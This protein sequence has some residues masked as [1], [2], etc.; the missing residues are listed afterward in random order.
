[1]LIGK[2]PFFLSLYLC[3]VIGLTLFVFFLILPFVLSNGS[4]FHILYLRDDNWHFPSAKIHRVNILHPITVIFWD[5]CLKI[6]G[7]EIQKFGKNLG[8]S[9]FFLNLLFICYEK[10]TYFINNFIYIPIIS[11]LKIKYEKKNKKKLQKSINY[12]YTNANEQKFH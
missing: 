2:C 12:S 7:F 3:T 1:M 6:P 4:K 5:W 10:K 9:Q 11:E 8:I